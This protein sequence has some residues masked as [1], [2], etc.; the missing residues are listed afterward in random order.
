MASHSSAEFTTVCEEM[1]GV[2]QRHVINAW[3]PR[4][5]DHERGGFFSDFD[6]RWRLRA[7]NNRILE[8]Q[9]RQTRV[10]AQL[11]EAFPQDGRWQDYAL[12]GLKFLQ[13]TMWDREYGGWFWAVDSFGKPVAGSTK[14][15]HSG[16][17]AVQAAAIVFRATGERAALA[18]A[19]EGLAWFDRYALDEEFGGFQSWLTREGTVI[20]SLPDVPAGA[21]DEDPLSHEVGLKDVNILGDWF[22]TLLDLSEVSD[23]ARVKLL[24]EQFGDIY[25]NRA[26][27]AAGEVHYGFH[28]D[29]KPQPGLEWYGYGF[30]ATERFLTGAR[31]LPKFPQMEARAHAIMLHTVRQARMKQGGFAYAGPGGL[32][33]RLMGQP[34]QVP[35]RVWWV[36]FEALRILALYAAAEN[37]DGPYGRALQAQ[38]KW[39]KAN[40]IDERFGGTFMR[41]RSDWRPWVRSWLPRQGWAFQKGDNWKDASHETDCLLMSIAALEGKPGIP[42]PKRS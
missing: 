39:I 9:A 2:L 41:P 21:D 8:F 34:M 31:V 14:H 29:W 27:T 5:I 15:A 38:W 10:V 11:A 32:P 23:L 40:L 26:T 13:E 19:E 28:P 25:L 20:R 3:F 6:Q 36:Q 33:H 17:Y 18:N 37:G 7:S 42:V 24:L 12:H 1:K 30:Q 22:E 4:C 16:A 35:A